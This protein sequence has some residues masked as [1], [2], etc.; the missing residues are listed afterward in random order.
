MQDKSVFESFFRQNYSDAVN[1]AFSILRDW[2]RS[3]DVVSE[4]MEYI[5]MHIR[6]FPVEKWRNYLCWQVRNRSIDFIR[7][8]RVENRYRQLQLFYSSVY[9][10]Y[11]NLREERLRQVMSEMENLSSRTKEILVECY[12]K[13]KKYRVVAE[14]Q[15]ISV[16]AVKKHIL[17]ALRF[18]REKVVKNAP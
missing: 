9:E 5:W 11:D 6:E 14:E 12:L 18:F 3:R 17:K 7:H 2:E 1:L 16:T 13:N 10:E 4:S 8:Q 15:G